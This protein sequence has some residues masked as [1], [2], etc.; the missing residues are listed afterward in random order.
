MIV[1]PLREAQAQDWEP[2]DSCE[3]CGVGQRVVYIPVGPGLVG[4]PF[5]DL[6]LHCA[7]RCTGRGH[8]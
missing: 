6:C 7:A 5:V 2:E 1:T 4:I 3:L 8:A